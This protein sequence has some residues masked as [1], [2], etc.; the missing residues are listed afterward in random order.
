MDCLIW[1]ALKF[2]GEVEGL[3]MRVLSGSGAGSGRFFQAF[4]VIE[5][6]VG[7]G[8]CSTILAQVFFTGWGSGIIVE[9]EVS[10]SSLV[11]IWLK[12]CS[13]FVSLL[14]IAW[15]IGGVED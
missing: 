8:A 14:S 11:N 13:C 4:G 6:V 2:V 7:G 3:R 5:V 12:V 9:E 10:W 1:S 15:G